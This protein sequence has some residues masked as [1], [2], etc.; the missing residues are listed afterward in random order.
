MILRS[1]EQG[2]EDVVYVAEKLICL[3]KRRIHGDI[4]FFRMD[5]DLESLPARCRHD[6][7]LC[8]AFFG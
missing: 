5:A 3:Q 4:L 8:G 2:A 6:H 1:A 7:V